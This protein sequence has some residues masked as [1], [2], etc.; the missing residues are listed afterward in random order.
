MPSP[1]AERWDARY[2]SS[3][4][5][6]DLSPPELV[7]T[8][9]ADLPPGARVLDVACGWGDAGLWLAQQG[10]VATLADVSAIALD[11]AAVRASKFGLDV[12]TV[13]TDLT[14]DDVPHSSS[15][16]GTWDVITCT[17]Y[18]DR[19]LLPRLAAALAPGGR[20][21]VAI[22]TTTN[23]ERHQRPSARFLLDPDELPTLVQ[24]PAW[25]QNVAVVHH[26][27]AWRTNGVFEAWGVF[28]RS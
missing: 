16:D 12:T 2:G 1:D 27:E 11:A 13:V 4:S 6:S 9:L 19:D 14:T 25:P 17:H 24:N 8:M 28:R 3:E 22:A 10:A 5:P 18:L 20:L 21:V 23:L 26:D 7:S 15:P